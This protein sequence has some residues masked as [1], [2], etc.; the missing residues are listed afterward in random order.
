M[1]DRIHIATGEEIVNVRTGQRMVFR[2]TADDSDGRELVIECW[3][4]RSAPGG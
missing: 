2:T 1:D 3:S 4:P